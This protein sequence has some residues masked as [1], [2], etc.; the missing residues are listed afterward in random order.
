MVEARG[1]ATCVNKPPPRGKNNAEVNGEKSPP[2]TILPY[3]QIVS[4]GVQVN[5]IY[6]CYLLTSALPLS[7]ILFMDSSYPAII[8]SNVEL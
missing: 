2:T 7:F 4:M 8:Q 5:L 3:C 1:K 6:I